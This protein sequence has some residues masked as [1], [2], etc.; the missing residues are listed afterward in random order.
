MHSLVELKIK[1]VKNIYFTV[2][3]YELLAPTQLVHH[4]FNI[5]STNFL[6]SLLILCS[7]ISLSNP[8]WI[9]VSQH[10]NDISTSN[11]PTVTLYRC[12]SHVRE[13]FVTNCLR[14]VLQDR[15]KTVYCRC[16]VSTSSVLDESPT[17]SAKTLTPPAEG[18]RPLSEGS[19]V[20]LVLSSLK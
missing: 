14:S 9:Y 8:A 7:H 4:N 17:T 13:H 1:K 12:S 20:G 19:N 15:T 3:T 16:W 10:P 2:S 11:L 5:T 6:S 18:Y